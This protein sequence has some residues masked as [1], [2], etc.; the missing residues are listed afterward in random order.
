MS[1]QIGDEAD[2]NRDLAERLE[3]SLDAAKAA[4]KAGAKRLDRAFRRGRSN[5]MV[6]LMLFVV[7]VF[8]F[9]YVAGKVRG[10]ARG[11]G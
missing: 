8:S 1:R 9:I 5:H 3:E 2:V 6:Y 4:L 7:A 11:V 10:V